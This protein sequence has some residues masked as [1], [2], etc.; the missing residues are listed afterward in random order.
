MI[1]LRKYSKLLESAL[2]DYG[3]AV[4]INNPCFTF[5]KGTGTLYLELEKGISSKKKEQSYLY[6]PYDYFRRDPLKIAAL[7]LSKMG[8]N[9]T[10]FA[11]QCETKPLD[12]NTAETFIQQ[13]HLMGPTQSGFNYGL[14]YK[15]QLLAVAS[16]AK[17]RKMNR[18]PKEKRSYE[19]IRFCCKSGYTVTGGL[20]K[21]MQHV[22][23]EKKA[24]DIMTHVDKQFSDGSSFKKA[25]FKAVASSAPHFFLV[26]KDSFQRQ[27]I[28]N[29]EQ[30][31][32]KKKYYLV[33]NAGNI[34]MI[35][36]NDAKV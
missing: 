3:V 4:A 23:I 15:G 33:Q 17:G 25:G 34:K 6:L 13:F 29:P 35:Y 5:R 21:L 11:R 8:L 1:H 18:L 31:F 7:V 27:L 24:G 12:K 20:S 30:N 14:F 2:Q 9:K 36:N 32:D 22:M 28:K 16:F 26:D 19:L 10:V